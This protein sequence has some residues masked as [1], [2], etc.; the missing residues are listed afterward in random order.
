MNDD[1]TL[2][3]RE[4]RRISIRS[5]VAAWTSSLAFLLSVILIFFPRLAARLA[6]GSLAAQEFLG[7]YAGGAIGILL[8][9]GVVVVCAGYVVSK[10]SVPRP[11]EL[12]S[13]SGSAKR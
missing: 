13:V 8:V 7:T 5:T 12:D 3:T 4:L 1:Q 2:L 6:E 11:K 10:I 9:L